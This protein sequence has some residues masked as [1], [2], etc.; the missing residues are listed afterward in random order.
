MDCAVA[1][2]SVDGCR[3]DRSSRVAICWIA[4]GNDGSGV[5]G[6]KEG[7]EEEEKEEE[8]QLEVRHRWGKGQL[9]GGLVVKPPV[10]DFA[11]KEET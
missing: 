11:T 10:E 1:I 9:S 4:A 5:D 8:R 7:E 2:R 3:S 6:V